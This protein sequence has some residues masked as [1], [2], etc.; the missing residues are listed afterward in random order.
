MADR[1]KDRFIEE[2]MKESYIDYAMSVIVGR[3]LPNV[4]D[5]LKPVHRRILYAMNEMGMFH[6]KPFKKSARIVG[7][8]L[9]RYHPH[10]DIS[11]YDAL[12]RMAQNFSLRYPLINGQG[13]WG[14]IDGDS[15]AHMR[16]TE[17]K[18][19]KLAEEL[20][21]DI[22]KDTV[23][24]VDNFDGSLKEPVV[25]PSKLPNLLING[26]SGIAVGMAT[27]IPP[28]NITEVIDAI[29][30]LIKNRE[31]TTIELMQYVKG[32]DF[33]TGGII[34]SGGLLN[35]YNNGKGIIKVKS[36]CDIEDN[37]II[38]NEIPYQVNKTNL[39]EQIA[40]LVKNGTIEGISDIRDESDQK[41]MR[42]VIILK[43][44]ANGELILNQLYKHSQ[45]QVSFGIN[46]LA[47]VNNE[48]KLLGLKEILN[49]FLKH[50]FEVVVR[51]TKF[52]LDKA[53]K[54]AHILV[55][56]K[57]A[58]ENIDP[59]VS[60]IKGSKDVN[61]ARIGL[62]KRFEFDEVQANAILEMRLH[63]LTSL[64]TN[65]I[66]DEYDELIKRIIYYKEILGDD[67]KVY[68][69]IENELKEI[70]KNYG[71]ERRTKIVESEENIEDEDLIKKEDVVVTVS[72]AGY[73]NRIAMEEYKTQGR[74][75]RGIKATAMK[76]NDFVDDL[77]ITNTHNYLLLFSDKGTCYWM[78]AYQIPSF[79]R[80]ARGT[81]LVNLLK[82]SKDEQI[83]SV[84]PVS[85]FRDDLFVTMLTKKGLVKRTKLSEY[86]RPRKGGIIAIHLKQGDK[87]VSSILSDGNQEL[88]VATANGRAARFDEKQVRVVGRNGQGVKA[89]K[90]VNDRVVGMC[91]AKNDILSVCEKG[92]GKR[93]SID[94]YRLINRGGKGVINIK[95]SERNGKVIEIRSVV[96][97][98]E[99]MLVSKKGV[100]IRVKAENIAKVGRNTQ[101]VRLMKLGEGDKVVSVG[102]VV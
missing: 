92:Y 14:S 24:F 38:I 49:E 102:K 7:D 81:N 33:P 97:S 76:D 68:G 101:G 77:F 80:Y 94:D 59:I 57:K 87:L 35:A 62:I 6:N 48:P 72:N 28:H 37:K 50:R 1:V 26:S 47:L 29:I 54:R 41:G 22:D 78:K 96:S 84:L 42:V 2:E 95:T 39:I 5:G 86:S 25:L 45:L 17:A 89:I 30:E 20:L 43:K 69:I 13:N 40:D 44:N 4:C 88:L 21:I 66:K 34:Y 74:G 15:A 83:N 36:V 91:F 12:V 90:L 11:I 52:D 46:L 58:L 60:L 79:G 65:K 27:N 63:R 99:L 10:G 85:E 18:L 53:E 67:Q 75:G 8:C 51:R 98:D 23:D 9:G 19:T 100:L 16:Y 70:R 64:E 3:A 73:V 32:P 61:E 93:T 56:L 71:D 31:I 82:L 55:G